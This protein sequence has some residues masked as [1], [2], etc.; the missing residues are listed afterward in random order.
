MPLSRK[1]KHILANYL[2]NN[3]NQIVSQMNRKYVVPISYTILNI[4]VSEIYELIISV[5][6]VSISIYTCVC[7]FYKIYSIVP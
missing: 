4:T 7:V 1:V 5:V 2:Y 6:P 3:A